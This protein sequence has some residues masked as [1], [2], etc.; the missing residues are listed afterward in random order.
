VARRLHMDVSVQTGASEVESRGITQ[1]TFMPPTMNAVRIHGRDGPEFLK[2]EDAPIPQPV[3]GGVGV[4][5]VQLAHWRSAR[6]SATAD[7]RDAYFLHEL[8][9]QE[10]I[11]YK[12]EDLRNTLVIRTSSST[13][14]AVGRRTA[15]GR[16]SEK[17]AFSSI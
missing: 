9:I 10:V 13:P 12:A 11:D 16:F 14:S 8:G 15:R 1:S 5:A 17:E 2:Y 6:V 4:F 3:P 7:S